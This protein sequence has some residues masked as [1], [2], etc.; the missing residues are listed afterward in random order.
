[1]VNSAQLICSYCLL[2][3]IRWLLNEHANLSVISFLTMLNNPPTPKRK[4]TIYLIVRYKRS[5]LSIGEQDFIVYVSA[6]KP[7]HKPITNDTTVIKT[8]NLISQWR[9]GEQGRDYKLVS[10]PKALPNC[11]LKKKIFCILFTE[12]I[13]KTRKLKFDA[14]MNKQK[15]E[16]IQFINFFV[17][18]AICFG[19]HLF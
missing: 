16:I 10:S 9:L 2:I 8:C 12:H 5:L 14:R 6:N 19:S 15:T 18:T 11:H 1:M 17:Y 3:S 7:I 4:T 13:F